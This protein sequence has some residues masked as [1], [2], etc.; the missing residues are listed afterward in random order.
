MCRSLT[1]CPYPLILQNLS[2][3]IWK[4]EM[5]ISALPSSWGYLTGLFNLGRTCKILAEKNKNYNC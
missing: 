3:L 5:L 1:V 4:M 2:L